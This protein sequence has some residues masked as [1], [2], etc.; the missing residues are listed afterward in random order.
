MVQNFSS[1][2]TQ[3]K[4][5]LNWQK[6]LTNH[7]K[8]LLIFKPPKFC[9][10][11]VYFCKYCHN[12]CVR[13][14]LTNSLVNL[15]KQNQ[16]NEFVY[17]LWNVQKFFW[18]YERKPATTVKFELLKNA[19]SVLIL[20]GEL[21]LNEINDTEEILLLSFRELFLDFSFE[22]YLQTVWTFRIWQCFAAAWILKVLS[23]GFAEKAKFIRKNSILTK[24]SV[25][26]NTESQFVYLL[27]SYQFRSRENKLIHPYT[28]SV[29]K[30]YFSLGCQRNGNKFNCWRD[31]K[32]AAF[33]SSWS[34]SALRNLPVQVESWSSVWKERKHNI[35]IKSSKKSNNCFRPLFGLESYETFSHFVQQRRQ[36]LITTLSIF[37]LGANLFESQVTKARVPWDV[38]SFRVFSLSWVSQQKFAKHFVSLEWQT[39]NYY[40]S[41]EAQKQK[42]IEQKLFGVRISSQMPNI[43]WQNT[44]GSN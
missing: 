12:I 33:L 21:S 20:S 30:I 3:K 34:C 5:L 25:S 41:L 15:T 17:L 40:L 42:A 16:Q 37:L 23:G 44:K 31:W 32:L 1:A 6:L 4:L 36:R 8:Y 26:W 13:E 29:R 27:I 18:V 19:L 28:S 43:S 9:W 10:F 38:K 7:S 14:Y 35:L 22:L 11:D 2:Y 39:K 24:W